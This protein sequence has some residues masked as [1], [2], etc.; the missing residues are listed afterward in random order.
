M[1]EFD[2]R[3]ELYARLALDFDG[4][5]QMGARGQSYDEVLPYFINDERR[6]SG[7]DA[8]YHGRQRKLAVTDCDW[9]HPLC[10]AFIEAAGDSVRTTITTAPRRWARVTISCP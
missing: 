6:I 7:G 10:D 8:G 5:A 4:W 1:L 3:T 9:Q 2:Q